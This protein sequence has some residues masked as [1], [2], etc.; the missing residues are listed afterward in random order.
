MNRNTFAITAAAAIGAVMLGTWVATLLRPA[1]DAFAVC[2]NGQVA[3]G[4]IGGPF[5]LVDENGAT[6]TDAQV[7]T[8]PTIVY[9]GYTF[10]PDIC[11]TDVQ[12]NAFAIEDLEDMGIIANGAFITIDPA[13]DTVDVVRDFT[14]SFHPRM[15]G[16]TGSQEQIDVAVR[17]WRVLAQ[18]G[19]GDDDFYLMNH[20]TFSYLAMPGV[21]Y[22]DFFNRDTTPEE[23]A[24]AAA[25]FVDVATN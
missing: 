14:A 4:S 3:G 2:R 16:L 23:I 19:E 15:I 17:A 6:V 13:R 1:D 20:S 9:F 22:V 5:T 18:R 12:R 8:A 7:F 21:G 25:C 11:P 10:C 24:T